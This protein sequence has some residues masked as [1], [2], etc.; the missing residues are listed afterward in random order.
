MSI[1][2]KVDPYC[3][4]CPDFEPEVT[5]EELVCDNEVFRTDTYIYCKHR[6]R[7]DAILDYLSKI[8]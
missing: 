5:K 8:K 6:L 3:E 7:C 1:K 2:L 4:Q